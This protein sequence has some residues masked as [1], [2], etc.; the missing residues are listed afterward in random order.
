MKRQ[1]PLTNTQQHLEKS[2]MFFKALQNTICLM[3]CWID[4]KVVHQEN[5]LTSSC[6][7]ERLDLLGALRWVCMMLALSV[8]AAIL[9]LGQSPEAPTL[10]RCGRLSMCLTF[11]VSL[12]LSVCP[13][14]QI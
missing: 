10:T 3:A 13:M 7:C 8:V 11:C 5:P 1:C 12:H 4:H 14:F 6:T 2:N 9:F